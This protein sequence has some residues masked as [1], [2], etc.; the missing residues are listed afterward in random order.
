[1]QA[2]AL[3]SEEGDKRDEDPKKKRKLDLI[4]WFTAFMNFA[5]AAHAAQVRSTAQAYSFCITVVPAF[6]FGLS[7][8]P[9]HT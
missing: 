6:R 5:I 3:F 2:M 1:M 4:R 9:W 7:V 8:R